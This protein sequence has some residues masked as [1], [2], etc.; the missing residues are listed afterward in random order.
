MGRNTI[1]ICTAA[2]EEAVHRH[3]DDQM[4]FLQVRDAGLYEI[5]ESIRSEELAHLNHAEDQL[6]STS[7]SSP[8]M[9]SAIARITDML[10][11]LSTYGASTRMSRALATKS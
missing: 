7:S 5:I 6:R 3:L 4:N 11:W 1:W 2:V 10:I 8:L 9:R